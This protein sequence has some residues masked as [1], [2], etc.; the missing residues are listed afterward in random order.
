MQLKN[1]RQIDGWILSSITGIL[2]SSLDLVLTNSTKNH[3]G[4]KLWS[5]TTL[6]TQM[7][8]NFQVVNPGF[9][10][11]TPANDVLYI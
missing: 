9:S 3:T 7:W 8:A 11:D 1:D 10:F 6:K 2:T 4:V 5:S